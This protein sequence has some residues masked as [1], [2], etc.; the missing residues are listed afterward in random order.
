[1][2][3]KLKQLKERIERAGGRMGMRDDIPDEVAELFLREI[4]SCPDCQ[5]EIAAAERHPRGRRRDH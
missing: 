1:M 5:A 3:P 2:N 4:L